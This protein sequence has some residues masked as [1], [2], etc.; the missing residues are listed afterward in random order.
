LPGDPAGPGEADQL[1][2]NIAAVAAFYEREEQ[3]VS[4]SQRMMERVSDFVGRPRF[5]G[6]IVTLVGCWILANLAVH[7]AGAVEFDPPPFIWLQGLF[8]VSTL[9]IST[10]VLARQ[11]RL[12]RLADLR[13][14]LDLKLTLLTE[15]KAAKMIDLLEELRRDLPNVRDRHDADAA[16]L[17]R[18]MTPG[19]VLAT[20]DEQRPAEERSQLGE[21]LGAQ[22]G[23]GL[24]VPDQRSGAP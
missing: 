5:L 9:L 10:V 22:L 21:I 15:Q 3:R 12:A 4:R 19:G 20:L 2:Q 13:A 6:L 17:Q 18:A 16:T 24:I 8:G 1:G 14:H 7:L 11:N 23:A